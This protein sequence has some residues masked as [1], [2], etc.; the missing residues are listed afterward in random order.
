MRKISIILGL[1][2]M[3]G[4]LRGEPH[5][6][7]QTLFMAQDDG[8]SIRAF[9][10]SVGTTTPVLVYYST[11][12]AQPQRTAYASPDRILTIQ[13]IQN[14]NLFCSTFP[15][16]SA[17]SGPRFLII[18][19]AAG[20]GDPFFQTYAAPSRVYCIFE[21]AAGASLLEVLG[22]VGYDSGD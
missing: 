7:N 21:P 4:I 22:W 8:D 12:T 11:Q 10:V 17:T 20:R 18:S 19:T 5:S 3:G 1:L 6:N 16:M 15:T 13:N 9:T 2:L 14:F